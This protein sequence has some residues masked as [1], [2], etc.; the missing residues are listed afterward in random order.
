MTAEMPSRPVDFLFLS[1]F[2]SFSIS[3]S[4]TPVNSKS[5]LINLDVGILLLNFLRGIDSERFLPT[6]EKKFSFQARSSVY[7]SLL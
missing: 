3:S 4:L 2:N 5:T 7:L 6:L 1:F